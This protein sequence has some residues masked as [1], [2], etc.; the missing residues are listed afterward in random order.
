MNF[1]DFKELKSQYDNLDDWAKVEFLVK[2]EFEEVAYKWELIEQVIK[3]E[4]E[5]D[6][7]RIQALKIAEIASIPKRYKD[8][9]A[10]TLLNVIINDKDYDVKNYTSSAFVNFIEYPEIVLISKKK[11]LDKNEDI[12]LR[13]NYYSVILKLKDRNEKKKIL[14]ELIMDAKF[15]KTAIRDL[16]LL[17]ES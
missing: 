17:V 3:T 8:I 14:S 13:Y 5:Y 16:N 15:Q 7:A 10:E 11:V 12:D 1:T 9:I 6:L 2:I 4:Q